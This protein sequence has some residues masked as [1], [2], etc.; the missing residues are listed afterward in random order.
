MRIFKHWDGPDPGNTPGRVFTASIGQEQMTVAGAFLDHLR[1][2][3][4]GAVATSAVAIEDFVDV[5]S[6]FDLWVGPDLRIKA[7]GNDLCALMSLYYRQMPSLGENSD[8]TGNDFVSGLKVPV[9]VAADPAKP[10]TM[11]ATRAAVT[12]IAT[13][14]IS[15]TGHWLDANPGRKPIHAVVVTFTS[16]ASTGDEIKDFRIAPVGR[17][18]AMILAMP[19]ASDFT[20]GN[21]DISAQRV[22]L[23]KDSEAVCELNVLGDA[24]AIEEVNHVSLSIFGDLLTRY[25]RFDF[26]PEGF[27]LKSGIFNL[28]LDNQDASDAIRFIPVIEME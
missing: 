21:I 20:D 6:E 7:D 11:A 10:F 27:D 8:A 26:R 23:L 24:E 17:L 28:K 5:L 25:K 15:V 4:K 13:E 14:T 3:L 22:K 12:N 19:A 1:I 9:Q 16:A 18:V 2:G